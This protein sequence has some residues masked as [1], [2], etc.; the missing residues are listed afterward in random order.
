MP[1]AKQSVRKKITISSSRLPSEIQIL[2]DERSL[3]S[4]E[5]QELEAR[6]TQ[7]L[8]LGFGAIGGIA[9]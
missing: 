2:I 3:L 8:V 6:I 5:L 9:S 1:K 7:I 4:V